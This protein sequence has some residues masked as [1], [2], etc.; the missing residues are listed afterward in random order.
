MAKFIGT[1]VVD[2]ER[3]KGCGLC[4]IACKKE[5]IVLSRKVNMSGYPYAEAQ[6][7][8]ECVGCAACGIVCPD[9]C[10]T[11]YKKKLEE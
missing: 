2:T 5:V 11:V 10:I 7:A 4:L 1:I 8:E 9:A 6:N 3:C